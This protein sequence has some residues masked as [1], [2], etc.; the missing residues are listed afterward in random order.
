MNDPLGRTLNDIIRNIKDHQQIKVNICNTAIVN[1]AIEN[2]NYSDNLIKTIYMENTNLSWHKILKTLYYFP[3]IE[4]L[5]VISENINGS[6]RTFLDII[7][8]FNFK[9]FVIKCC[10]T[11]EFLEKWDNYVTNGSFN[12]FITE[13]SIDLKR[14]HVA[15]LNNYNH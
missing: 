7:N 8:N 9:T 11:K 6:F 15:K 2:M 14:I 1:S 5:F 12:V 13:N 10:L 4:H 3:C